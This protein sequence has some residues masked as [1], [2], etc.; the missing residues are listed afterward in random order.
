MYTAFVVHKKLNQ[1]R[2]MSLGLLN[3]PATFIRL[4]RRLLYGSKQIDY[5]DDV[6]AHTC[7]SQENLSCNERYLNK[8]SKDAFDFA[9]FQLLC[10]FPSRDVFRTCI[11]NNVLEQKSE[12]VTIILKASR[13][14]DKKQLRSLLGLVGYYRQFVPNFTTGS[15]QLTDLTKKNEPNRLQWGVAQGQ[16]L[17]TLKYHIANHPIMTRSD[18]DKECVLQTDGCMALERFCHKKKG[19]YA[20][21]G[22]S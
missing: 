22:L 18:F 2:V 8:C 16:A 12:M 13:P 15:V 14:V 3:A 10:E 11:I 5:V 9:N 17:Q 21:R 4:M 20:S 1:F 7:S 6:L 19:Y